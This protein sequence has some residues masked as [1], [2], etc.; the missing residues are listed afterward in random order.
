MDY[1]LSTNRVETFYADI[2]CLGDHTKSYGSAENLVN[3][4]FYDQL[5]Y[6]ITKKL[7]EDERACIKSYYYE[8]YNQ[9]EIAKRMD[10]DQ[11]FVSRKLLS[12][13]EKLLGHLLLM[14]EKAYEDK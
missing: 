14:K 7:D 5:N 10:R 13:R 9:Y 3:I 2:F 4:I 11:S 6:L 8:D 12:A 1:R